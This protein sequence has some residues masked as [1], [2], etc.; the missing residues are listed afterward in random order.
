MPGNAARVWL[1]EGD[2]RKPWRGAGVGWRTE[3]SGSLGAVRG[4]AGGR[5]R[6]EA[7]ARCGVWLADGSVGKPWRGTAFGWRAEASGSLGA[8]WAW[9]R[10]RGI[11]GLWRGRNWVGDGSDGWSCAQLARS[12]EL[13]QAGT[14]AGLTRFT[15]EWRCGGTLASWSSSS[16]NFRAPKNSPQSVRSAENP[17]ETSPKN[18]CAPRSRQATRSPRPDNRGSGGLNRSPPEWVKGVRIRRDRLSRRGFRCWGHNGR[19]EHRSR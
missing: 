13:A 15:L 14:S 18:L 16:R 12:G 8:V 11:R 9:Q 5:K 10:P 1:A 6:R 2:V 7:L 3:A 4:L 19:H 17:A